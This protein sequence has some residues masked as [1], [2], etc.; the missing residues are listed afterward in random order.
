MTIDSDTSDIS[1]FNTDS[2]FH[3][4]N[5]TNM[6]PIPELAHDMKT[7]KNNDLLDK[8]CISYIGNKS[9]L[10]VKQHKLMISI[11]SKFEEIHIDL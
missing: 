5:F 1:D 4:H 10:I 2:N 7:N 6:Q 9:I 8:L 3:T 11:S